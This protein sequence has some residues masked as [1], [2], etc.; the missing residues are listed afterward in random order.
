MYPYL[1]RII[2]DKSIKKEELTMRSKTY[3]EPSRELNVF[4]E[5]EVLVI[6]A[7]PGGVSAAIAAARE[8]ADTLLVE[9]PEMSTPPAE[10]SGDTHAT[11]VS[12]SGRGEVSKTS[13]LVH[14]R[15]SG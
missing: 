9:R 11:P 4:D 2:P 7:G 5:V 10:K 13:R 14:M 8:G 3:V 6:G 12:A 15:L 1:L